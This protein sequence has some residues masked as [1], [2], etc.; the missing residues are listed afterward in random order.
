MTF[1]RHYPAGTGGFDYNYE[2]SEVT[3]A[4]MDG[5]MQGNNHIGGF[6]LDWN[7]A[8]AQSKTT[9]PFGY[10]MSFTEPSGGSYLSSKDHP[11]INIIPFAN[12]N[13]QRAV[14]DSSQYKRQENFDKERT[15]FFNIARN[16]TLWDYL[17][18]ELKVG[19]KIKQK[20]R[21]KDNYIFGW[22]NYRFFPYFANPDG[23]PIDL[24]TTR[25][26]GSTSGPDLARFLDSS[27][28]TRDLLGLYRMTPLIS[29]DAFKQWADL[30]DHGIFPQSPPDYGVNGVALLGNYFV[31]ERVYSGFVMNTLDIGQEATLIVGVRMEQE[32]NDYFAKFSD[33]STGGTG[34]MVLLTGKV[35]DTTSHYTETVWL[36][37]AQLSVRPTDYLTVRVA[38]YRA[39]ARPDFNL[40]LPQFSFQETP[41]GTNL[42]AGNPSLKDSKAWN[43]EVNTQVH[44]NVL[45]LASL[46]AFY[47]RIDNLYHQANNVNISWPSGGPNQALGYK[48]WTTNDRSGAYHRLDDLL[49]QLNMSSWKNNTV[50]AKYLHYTSNTFNLFIAYNSP[51]PSYAW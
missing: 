17:T 31:T 41:G 29:V 37:S 45:G 42:V 44:D 12:N 50:F 3:T 25:F 4:T 13:F 35:V 23:T 36:P 2:K 14:L 48:G 28:H 15:A 27:I 43:F 46:S 51:T 21:W 22:N 34:S 38:A 39:L 10:R 9:N 30:T 33:Q 18:N 8:F 40:R 16:V 11:E 49:D 26:A 6:D 24:S 1:E 7:A 5:S 20:E 19:G 32:S 47:K